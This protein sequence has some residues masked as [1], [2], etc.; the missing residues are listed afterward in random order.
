M[1][2]PYEV[3][4]LYEVEYSVLMD[5]TQYRHCPLSSA[6]SGTKGGKRIVPLKRHHEIHRECGVNLHCIMKYP[7]VDRYKFATQKIPFLGL[8]AGNHY[9]VIK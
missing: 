2:T 1:Q 3:E 4:L 6:T 8:Q 9:C 5:P 7:T